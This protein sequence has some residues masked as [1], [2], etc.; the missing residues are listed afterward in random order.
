MIQ[1][2]RSGVLSASGPMDAVRGWVRGAKQEGV[3]RKPPSTTVTEAYRPEFKCSTT[4]LLLG[5]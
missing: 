1:C 5:T 2:Y 3:A 4:P